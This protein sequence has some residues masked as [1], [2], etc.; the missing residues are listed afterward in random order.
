MIYTRVT[1]LGHHVLAKQQVLALALVLVM[2][3]V[4]DAHKP[5]MLDNCWL[6]GRQ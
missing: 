3:L 1:T 2:V 6:V 4:V 5:L